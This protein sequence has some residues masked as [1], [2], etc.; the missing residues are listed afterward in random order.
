MAD[1]DDFPELYYPNSEGSFAWDSPCWNDDWEHEL[2]D[3][4]S[5]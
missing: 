4:M 3:G 1:A 5:P 2:W